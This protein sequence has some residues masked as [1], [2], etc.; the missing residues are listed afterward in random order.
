MALV[1]GADTIANWTVTFLTKFLDDF[2]KHHPLPVIERLTVDSLTVKQMLT[3]EDRSVFEAVD[4]HVIGGTGQPAFEHSWVDYGAPY[5]K[6]AFIKDPAGFIRLTGVI[7]SGV[8][9]SSA[10][11]LPPGYRPAVDPG[12]FGVVSNGLFGR[13]DVAIDGTVTPISPSSNSSVS[14]EGIVFKAA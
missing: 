7:K 3:V 10:F 8:V 5:S 1:Q 2:F 4:L 14:L 9:G 13:V 6:A 11:T 12:P